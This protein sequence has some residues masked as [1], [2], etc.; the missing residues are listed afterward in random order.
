MTFVLQCEAGGEEAYRPWFNAWAARQG[1]DHRDLLTFMNDQRVDE[2]HRTGATTT[3]AIERVPASTVSRGDHP[4]HP[5][6][7][8]TWS[9]PPGVPEPTV[10]IATYAFDQRGNVVQVCSRYLGVSA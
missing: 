3:P 1:A 4:R 9:S 7:G 8:L 5:A 6:Y 10:G 2:I